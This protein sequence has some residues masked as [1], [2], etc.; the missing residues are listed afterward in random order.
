MRAAQIIIWGVL[1][2][3]CHLGW[4]E[5]VKL[6]TNLHAEKDE[7]VIFRAILRGR[8]NCGFMRCVYLVRQFCTV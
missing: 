4:P 2:C 3:L 7:M 5:E 1:L 8:D 6:F